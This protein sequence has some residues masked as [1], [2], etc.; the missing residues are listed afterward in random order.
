MD[1]ILDEIGE[2]WGTL[3]QDEQIALSEAV[4]GRLLMLA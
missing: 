2:K 1:T 3:A 4:A